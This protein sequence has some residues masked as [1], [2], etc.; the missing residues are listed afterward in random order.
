MA[1]LGEFFEKLA[2]DAALMEAY[3]A[4]PQAVMQANGLSE[5]EI[6]AVLSGDQAKLKQL[7]GDTSQYKSFLL[8]VS[9]KE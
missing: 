9:P 3:Q 1:N 7:S 4:D 5:E 8:I 6:Q 2:S